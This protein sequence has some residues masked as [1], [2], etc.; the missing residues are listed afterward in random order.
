MA[1][2][3]YDDAQKLASIHDMCV[4][5]SQTG[6]G[7]KSQ[8]IWTE[9]LEETVPSIAINIGTPASESP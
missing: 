9:E 8:G 2:D 4:K 1:A 3:V 7:R 5:W 6:G